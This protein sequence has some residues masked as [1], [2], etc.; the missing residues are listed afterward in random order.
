MNEEKAPNYRSGLQNKIDEEY[1]DSMISSNFKEEQYQIRAELR[2]NIILYI[3]KE[4]L[5]LKMMK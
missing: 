1:N 3:Q 4:K 5:L 2:K